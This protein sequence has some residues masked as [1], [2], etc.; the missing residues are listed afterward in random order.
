MLAVASLAA[1]DV[2]FADFGRDPGPRGIAALFLVIGFRA[3]SKTD[4]PIPVV[5]ASALLTALVLFL[6]HSKVSCPRYICLSVA[7]AMLLTILFW[8]RSGRTH[9]RSEATETRYR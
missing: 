5:A 8:G 4:P 7:A 9:R 3:L 6:N 2:L 1:S